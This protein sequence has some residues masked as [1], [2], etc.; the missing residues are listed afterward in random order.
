MTEEHVDIVTVTYNRIEYFKAFI[1]YLHLFTN[2]PFRLIVIDNGSTDGTRDLIEKLIKEGLVWKKVFNNENMKLGA[3]LTEGF[4]C[5]E[6]KYYVTVADDMTPPM[7]KNI[8]WL[9]LIKD[10]MDSDES[11]GSINFMGVRKSY[12]AFNRKVRPGIID[13]I[14]KE[15]GKRLEIFN[16]LQELL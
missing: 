4:K 16:R 14:K 6:S 12:S 11:V 10:K 7:F 15:G 2:H 9:T 8:C 13:R 3:A 1:E 5:V